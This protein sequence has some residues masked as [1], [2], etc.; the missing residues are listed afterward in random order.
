MN[1]E[2]KEVINLD[3]SKIRMDHLNF[4]ERREIE[5]LCKGYSDIFYFEKSPLTFTNQIK[6]NIKTSDEIPL[7]LKP[8]AIR[9]F[10]E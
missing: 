2:E 7:Y 3:F 9:S 4:E 10:T 8:I 1:I 5:K 6:H